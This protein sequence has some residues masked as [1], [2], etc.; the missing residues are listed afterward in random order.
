MQR[1]SGFMESIYGLAEWI[2]R[3]SLLN[4]QWISLN[5]PVLIISIFIL[6]NPTEALL[7]IHILLLTVWCP[8]VCFPS[9][10]AVM[11]K[12]R[13]WVM[14]SEQ[15]GGRQSYW[16]YLKE[17]YRKKIF[18]GAWLTLLWMIWGADFYYLNLK[19]PLLGMI[20]IFIGVILFVYTINALS[21]YVHYNIPNKALLKNTFFITVGS[22]LLFIV[23]LVGNSLVWYI[24]TVKFL[25]LLPFFTISISAFLSFWAFYRFT[26]KV[27][28]K[29]HGENH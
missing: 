2:T 25:F 8:V 7:F 23:V 17:N 18:F 22:P 28:R 11:A 6:Y 9:T 3:F 12:V 24:S 10:I 29:T 26:L 27:K 4:L 21:M 19:F 20:L 15:I 1:R 13:E 16:S 5:L 14:V